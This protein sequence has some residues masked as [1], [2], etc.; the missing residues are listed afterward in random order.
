MWLGIKAAAVCVSLVVLFRIFSSVRDTPTRFVLTAVWLRYVLAAFHDFTYGPVVAGFSI[1]ALASI[2][3]VGVGLLLVRKSALLMQHLWPAYLLVG[4]ILLSG[5][6]NASPI[7]L[8]DVLT[9]W[10]Y[11]IVIGL[12]AYDAVRIHG[13]PQFAKILA[14]AFIVPLGMQY[15]S[16]ALGAAKALESDG[17]VSYIGMYNHESIFSIT[18]LTFV[19]LASLPGAWRRNMKCG[20]SS[21]TGRTPPFRPA[22]TA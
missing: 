13:L 6:I 7:D 2:G 20:S 16:F 17:S 19:F 15:L 11:F 8:V 22:A 10:G 12:C 5:V 18:L 9:K 3:V 4:A 1:N 21:G 14:A